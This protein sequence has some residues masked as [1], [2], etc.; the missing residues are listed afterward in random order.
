MRPPIYTPPSGP[1]QVSAPRLFEKT[2]EANLI[3]LS[4]N[5]Y[6]LLSRSDIANLFP[7]EPDALQAAAHKQADFL[8]GI[9]GGPPRFQEKHGPP[10]M[11]ARHLP[12]SIDAS[13]RKVWLQCFQTALGDGSDF[14]LTPK[15]STL[16]LEWLEAFSAWMV[17]APPDP[18]LPPEAN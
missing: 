3:R 14:G 8:I 10:R 13:A 4:E 9:L 6:N 2:G 17:N 12:F 5:F 11:R 7:Q 16:L 15:E 18:N 1:P